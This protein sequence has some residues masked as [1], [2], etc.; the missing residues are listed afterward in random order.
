MFRHYEN[1]QIT[2]TSISITVLDKTEHIV[3][4]D[5]KVDWMSEESLTWYGKKGESCFLGG[6]WLIV[7]FKN[8]SEFKIWMHKEV[9]Y[10]INKSLRG[11]G[12]FD[13]NYRKHIRSKFSRTH[14]D[15]FFVDNID[16]EYEGDEEFQS[17]VT[18][19]K[20]IAEEY[21]F[22]IESKP[23][24]VISPSWDV[25]EHMFAYVIIKDNQVVKQGVY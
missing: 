18:D 5:K 25:D 14:M 15:V 21:S 12:L 1:I 8:G 7:H 6:K 17:A 23:T 22:G 19:V 9:R 13:L 3:E 10:N 16:K 24:V 2:E 11:S 4:Y 20:N